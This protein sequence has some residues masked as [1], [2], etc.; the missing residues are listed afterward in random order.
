MLAP[1]MPL[2]MQKKM[3]FIGLYGLGVNSEFNYHQLLRDDADRTR[4]QRRRSSTG[5]FDAA[6]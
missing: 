6:R 3:T 5:F 1:A 4:I 2:V